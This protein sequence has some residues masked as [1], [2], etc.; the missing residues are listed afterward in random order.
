VNRLAKAQS[1]KEVLKRELKNR[2]KDKTEIPEIV[3][4][5]IVNK[6]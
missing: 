6:A 4:G 2:R 5:L 1:Q 3:Q